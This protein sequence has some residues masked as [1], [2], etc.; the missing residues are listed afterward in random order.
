LTNPF[1]FGKIEMGQFWDN[2]F[3]AYILRR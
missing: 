1:S 3:F 2:P